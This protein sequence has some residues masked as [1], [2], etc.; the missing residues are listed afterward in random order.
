MYSN[1]I[2]A[3]TAS[4]GDIYVDFL[5]ATWLSC[6]IYNRR[7]EGATIC[8]GHLEFVSSQTDMS[9]DVK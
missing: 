1:S 9:L 5:N 7:K 3:W 4:Y 2:L 6:S 8:V